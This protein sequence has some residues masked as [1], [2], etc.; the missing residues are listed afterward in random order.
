M[1]GGPG[2]GTD[3]PA[4]AGHRETEGG[5]S[6]KAPEDFR[7]RVSIRLPWTAARGERRERGDHAEGLLGREVTALEA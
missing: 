5:S 6:G 4:S 2:S 7:G 3:W 1:T